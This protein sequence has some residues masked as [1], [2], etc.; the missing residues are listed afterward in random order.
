MTIMIDVYNKYHNNKRT[1]IQKQ[2]NKNT[3]EHLQGR[4]ILL[5]NELYQ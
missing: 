5:C 2:P 1:K 3:L 4:Y